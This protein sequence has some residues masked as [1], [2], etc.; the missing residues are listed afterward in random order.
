M[1][2]LYGPEVSWKD[3][4]LC[5]LPHLH[6]TL[7]EVKPLSFRKRRVLHSGDGGGVGRT[8][9]WTTGGSLVGGR[10]P[11]LGLAQAR[12]PR[13]PGGLVA[14]QRVH[15]RPMET[16]DALPLVPVPGPVRLWCRSTPPVPLLGRRPPLGLERGTSSRSSVS[17]TVVRR[18]SLRSFSGSS[19]CSGTCGPIPLA[20]PRRCPCPA[21]TPSEPLTL[22]LP[23]GPPEPVPDPLLRP[24]RGVR[25]GGEDAGGLAA[26]ARRRRSGPSR[27]RA[28]RTDAS[29]LPDPTGP[30]PRWLGGREVS[31]DW[32]RRMRG[33]G[34]QTSKDVRT[35][36][37]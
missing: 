16:P 36:G 23:H 28:S 3:R 14:L 8:H 33:E 5:L 7:L 18:S 31:E 21:P 37:G 10:G 24:A 22:P 34:L 20:R 9:W 27:P 29:P 25:V 2:P 1:V 4:Y 35:S 13:P 17:C 11:L 30:A 6:H 15:D 12:R 26:S 32:P 19:W